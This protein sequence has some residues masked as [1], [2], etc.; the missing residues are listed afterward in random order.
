MR[1]Q[2]PTAGD[3]LVAVA[4]II[5]L[6]PEVQAGMGFVAFILICFKHWII[7]GIIGLIASVAYVVRRNE[8]L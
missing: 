8:H 5:L 6:T 3:V 2:L 1:M 4:L 7:G